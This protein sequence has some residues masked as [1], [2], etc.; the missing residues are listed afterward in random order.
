VINSAAA[1]LVTRERQ[2]GRTWYILQTFAAAYSV[3]SCPGLR[4]GM[5]ETFTEEKNAGGKTQPDEGERL[6]VFFPN[7]KL[8]GVVRHGSE[9]ANEFI[10]VAITEMSKVRSRGGKENCGSPVGATALHT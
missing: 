4:P 1:T 5:R 6:N 7:T 2:G 10:R 9:G 8:E 3:L